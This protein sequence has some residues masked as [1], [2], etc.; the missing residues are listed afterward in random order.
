MKLEC[1]LASN[2]LYC[3]DGDAY[4]SPQGRALADGAEDW[5]LLLQ[6]DSDEDG[7]GWMWGDLGRIYF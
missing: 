2:G 1:Q 3:G 6:I 4:G 5:R 7:P